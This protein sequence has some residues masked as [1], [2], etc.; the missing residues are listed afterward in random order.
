MVVAKNSPFKTLRDLEGQTLAFPGQVSF[1]ATLLPLAHLAQQGV[2]VTPNYVSSHDSVY[3]NV[4]KGL[5]AAG[6]GVMK[7]LKGMDAR[8]RSQLRVL[9]QTPVYT[10]HPIA[11]HERVPRAVRERVR[12]VLLTMHDDPEGAHYLAKLGFKGV[13]PAQDMD[14]EE[15]R[16]LALPDAKRQ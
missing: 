5:Y 9:W 15:L 4:A 7:T 12:E 2:R 10:S 13:M 3:H 11:V 1:A 14:Y 8:T 16:W 6:G